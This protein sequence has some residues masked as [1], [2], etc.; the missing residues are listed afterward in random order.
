LQ[1]IGL[2]QPPGGAHEVERCLAAVAVAEV[3]VTNCSSSVD[4]GERSDGVVVGG[5][6]DRESVRS[7]CSRAKAGLRQG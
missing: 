4:A 3:A 5:L 1:E 2:V 6:Q 7:F